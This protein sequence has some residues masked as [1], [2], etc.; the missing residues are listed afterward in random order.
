MYAIGRPAHCEIIIIPVPRNVPQGIFDFEHLD[1]HW[2][3]ARRIGGGGWQTSPL[4]HFL[5]RESRIFV[6]FPTFTT[7]FCLGPGS[8]WLA[9][10]VWMSA[11]YAAFACLCY[12]NVFGSRRGLDWGIVQHTHGG[13]Q[14]DLCCRL[15]PSLELAVDWPWGA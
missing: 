11:V 9:W 7:K 15:R 3:G 6:I 14:T 13:M 10:A 4:S 5:M 12:K 1:P 2:P 8:Q